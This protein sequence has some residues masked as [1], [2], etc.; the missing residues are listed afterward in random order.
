MDKIGAIQEAETLILITHNIKSLEKIVGV[1][2]LNQLASVIV[3]HK[4]KH[5]DGRMVNKFA[6]AL[7]QP[8]I[9][10]PQLAGLQGSMFHECVAGHEAQQRSS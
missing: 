3:T 9:L 2:D 10:R 7:V 4:Q 1:G 8:F 5:E 6:N